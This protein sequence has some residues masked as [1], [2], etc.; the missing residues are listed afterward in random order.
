[1]AAKD[2]ADIDLLSSSIVFDEKSLLIKDIQETHASG[3]L[4]EY[5]V[6]P[7]VAIVEDIMTR[8]NPLSANITYLGDPSHDDLNKSD[9]KAVAQIA[10]V[11]ESPINYISYVV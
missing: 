7:L 5:D 1:M 11:L 3:C 4:D 2:N 6:K 10:K 9:D 8:A